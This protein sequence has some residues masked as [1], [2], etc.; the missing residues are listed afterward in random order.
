MRYHLL[1]STTPKR[2]LEFH[3]ITCFSFVL[4]DILDERNLVSLGP[5]GLARRLRWGWS[6][7]RAAVTGLHKVVQV[8]NVWEY[9]TS[10]D[11]GCHVGAKS[12]IEIFILLPAGLL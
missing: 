7:Q 12:K 3:A 4:S 8:D 10:C 2:R 9:V 1:G 11:T 5:L 6:L